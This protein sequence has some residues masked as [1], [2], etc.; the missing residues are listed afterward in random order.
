MLITYW[1]PYGNGVRVIS[2]RCK[3]MTNII[4]KIQL[5]KWSKNDFKYIREEVKRFFN[6]EKN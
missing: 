5:G 6:N 2:L 1:F 4:K 3:L